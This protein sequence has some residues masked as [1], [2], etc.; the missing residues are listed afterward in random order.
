MSAIL[1]A[2]LLLILNGF[3]V[4]AEF[5]LVRVRSTQIDLHVA[6][7][8]RSAKLVSRI[9]NNVDPY[10]SAA[11][12]GITL[13]S[14]GLGWIGEPAVAAN[15]G[16][17]FAWLDITM[18]TETLHW[19]S[20]LIAFSAISFLHIVIGEQA[21]KSYAIAKPVSTSLFVA[22]P[23]RAVYIILY[24]AMMALTWASALM[25]KLVGVEP[26]R[27]HSMAVSADELRH[28]AQHSAT[29][30]TISEAQGSLLDKVF[31]FSGRVAREIMVP[32]NRVAALNIEQPAQDVL[33]L[34]LRTGHSRYPLYKGDLDQIVG[35]L[36]LKD[37]LPRLLKGEKIR[38]LEQ[39]AREVLYVPES[40][41]A[42]QLLQLFKQR[43]SHL[44]VVVD[45]YGGVS[46]VIALEDAL[47]ELVGEIEDEFDHAHA[48]EL[49]ET[50]E[51]LSVDGRILLEDLTE[52]LALDEVE[53]EADTISGYVMEQLG[54]IASIG[55]QVMLGPWRVQ[56][57]E[58]DRMRIDRVMLSQAGE[59]GIAKPE[60]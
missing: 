11:Q 54:R 39:Y 55:D 12:L 6:E 42:Q 3:F 7:G 4:A 49:I 14:L 34:A 22:Y 35:I 50:E 38:R 45:E 47:E 26:A 10:L 8:S 57:T 21:P 37:L 31:I 60:S 27:G 43:R 53:S 41:P 13:A 5:A 51:G 30:G 18:Q 58:M 20:F 29:D 28:I 2:I 40:A 48:P 23:M 25:L 32:R 36:H 33:E 19:L 44:A 1:L 46:G 59:E 9:I 24:P 52:R 16:R 15:L 17:L 56:V